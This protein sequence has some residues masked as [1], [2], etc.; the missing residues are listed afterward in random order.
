MVDLPYDIKA[1]IRDIQKGGA[2][3][4]RA[5]AWMQ[6]RKL[7]FSLVN[8]G[9]CSQPPPSGVRCTECVATLTGGDWQVWMEHDVRSALLKQPST[10]INER[11][12]LI[13][14]QGSIFDTTTNLAQAE[15]EPRQL[16]RLKVLHSHLEFRFHQILDRIPLSVPSFS[17]LW[18]DAHVSPYQMNVTI[19][20]SKSYKRTIKPEDFHRLPEDPQVHTVAGANTTELR[21]ICLQIEVALG[22]I[23]GRTR[24]EPNPDKLTID[25]IMAIQFGIRL[26][27]LMAKAETVLAYQVFAAIN[28]NV[29]R[30][31]QKLSAFWSM[32]LSDFKDYEAKAIFGMLDRRMDPENRKKK[33]RIYQKG[34]RRHDGSYLKEQSF[35]SKLRTLRAAVE[36]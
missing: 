9:S 1:T 15:S 24:M 36:K 7:Q 2:S 35:L 19:S 3:A 26:G 10:P 30:S 16:E 18:N 29:G 33:M 8:K 32:I 4:R 13:P 22:E 12:N 14:I 27:S 21:E 31:G 34:L 5:V 28:S 6:D 20:K 23:K 11:F 17:K 25:P